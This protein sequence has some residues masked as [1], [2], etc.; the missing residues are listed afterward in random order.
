MNIYIDKKMIGKTLTKEEYDTLIKIENNMKQKESLIEKERLSRMKPGDKL[1][2]FLDDC[3]IN[4]DI[5]NNIHRDINRKIDQTRDNNLYLLI[6]EDEIEE[7]E[8]TYWWF[9]YYDV[10]CS[11]VGKNPINQVKPVIKRWLLSDMKNKRVFIYDIKTDESELL[12]LSIYIIGNV[13][14]K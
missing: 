4:P 7:D 9:Q 12:Y 6:F 3:L 11:F 2:E 14:T 5:V 10:V 1:D 8:G 13:S